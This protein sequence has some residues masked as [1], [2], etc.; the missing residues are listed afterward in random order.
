MAD[1]P[2]DGGCAHHDQSS[3]EV[4]RLLGG[5]NL[6]RRARCVQPARPRALVVM[7][8]P[9]A[10]SACAH[11]GRYDLVHT[12]GLTPHPGRTEVGWVTL[13]VLVRSTAVIEVN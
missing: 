13:R 2:R 8:T 11:R 10:T 6:Q 5:R 1:E 3:E 12:Q 7:D 4:G 9:C